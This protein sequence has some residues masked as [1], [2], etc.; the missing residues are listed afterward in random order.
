[1]YKKKFAALAVTTALI[2]VTALT[3]CDK[4]IISSNSMKDM[5]PGGENMG[6]APNGANGNGNQ[7][8][9]PEKPEGS[10]NTSVD[11]TSN[12]SSSSD[13]IKVVLELR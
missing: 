11:N 8:T 13:A 10:D 7:E 6:Q 5:Q 2:T 4:D 1:M 9:P 3:A 12:N